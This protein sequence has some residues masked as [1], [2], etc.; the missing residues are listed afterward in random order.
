MLTSRNATRSSRAYSHSAGC[1]FE[2]DGAH[3]R[4]TRGNACQVSRRSGLLVGLTAAFDG[5]GHRSSSF[6]RSAASR[7]ISGMTWP[8]VFMV[9]ATAE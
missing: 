3:Q 1:R 4:L 7:C 9:T 8:Y 5:N 2:S 6:M